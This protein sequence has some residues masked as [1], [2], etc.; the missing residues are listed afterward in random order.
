MQ[1]QKNELNFNG[2]NIY[3]GIDVHLKSWTVT[4]R[5][6]HLEHKRFSPPPNAEALHNYLTRNFPGATYYSVY[7]SGF[8]GF[9]IH[10]QLEALGI[11]NIGGKG[12]VRMRS[13]LVKDIEQNISCT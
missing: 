3:V 9:W 1:T 7:E 2:Q 5:S 11:H 12:T 8:C 13:T 6:E 4:I 10:R